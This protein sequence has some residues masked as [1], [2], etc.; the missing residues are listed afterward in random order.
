LSD[1]GSSFWVKYINYIITYGAYG[2][3]T[4]HNAGYCGVGEMWGNYI[5]WFFLDKEFPSK[6]YYLNKTE[7]WY[8]PGFL[9]DVDNISD[10]TTAEIYSCLT[11][12]TDTFIDLITQL[13][14]KTTNDEQVDNAFA[15]YTDWP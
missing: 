1:P 12:S 7:D 5:G 4:G 10:I 13:K 2:N 14:T 8:N 3:G 15:N 11:S 6:K 9:Q